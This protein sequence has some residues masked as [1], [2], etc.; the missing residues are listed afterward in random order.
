MGAVPP[1]ARRGDNRSKRGVQH[2]VMT[3]AAGEAVA[4]EEKGPRFGASPRRRGNTEG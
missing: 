2:P 4:S 1:S 3:S